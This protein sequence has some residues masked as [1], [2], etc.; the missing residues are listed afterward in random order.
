MGKLAYQTSQK[1][2]TCTLASRETGSITAL[3][4]PPDAMYTKK[5]RERDDRLS[6]AHRKNI[7]HR[8]KSKTEK[9]K[10]DLFVQHC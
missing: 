4:N 6:K 9:T 7:Q 8:W 3:I 5:K 10:R 2:S 1:K